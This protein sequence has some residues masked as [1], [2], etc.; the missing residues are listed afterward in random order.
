MIVYAPDEVYLMIFVRAFLINL[1]IFF[2]FKY[3]FEVKYENKIMLIIEFLMYQWIMT[4]MYFK[5]NPILMIITLI[6][7]FQMAGFVHAKGRELNVICH[8]AIFLSVFLLSDYLVFSIWRRWDTLEEQLTKG[9]RDLDDLC[10]IN[11]VFIF[12]I[13][14][15]VIGMVRKY[16]K[17]CK[18][19]MLDKAV[20]IEVAREHK[21]NRKL[22]FII[23][24][25]KILLLGLS[26]PIEAYM[27][28]W[29]NL[30]GNQMMCIITDFVCIGI[31]A[32]IVYSFEKIEKAII[33][34]G[35]L[36]SIKA[37]TKMQLES[38]MRLSERYEG[39][40]KIIHDIRKHLETLDAI[41]Y[42]D[43][44]LKKYADS[45]EKK[46]DILEY[47]FFCT[48]HILQVIMSSKLI[49]CENK[50]ISVNINMI[51]EK[52]DF[53]EDI[54]V[55]AI[56]ANLWDNA[57]EAVENQKYRHRDIKIVI[58]REKGF[59]VLYFEN[60]CGEELLYDNENIVSTKSKDR[61]WG[62]KIIGETIRK[63]GGEFEI[64]TDNG[65]FKAKG[66]IPYDT[67]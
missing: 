49:E 28:S 57:I 61:G 53:M 34:D 63:Y 55:T 35:E 48:N 13:M 65:Y 46:I 4:V 67:I 8:S 30:K 7:C 15:I 58:G 64:V 45:I 22:S 37:K 26:I 33:Y 2:Y 32:V 54:D 9:I 23:E 29:Y 52:F 17:L 10:Y 3:I 60:A 41:L 16:Q 24:I 66:I 47:G 59:I 5:I 21:H 20:G 42:N 38:Y 31:S 51:E 14:V 25:E 18:A 1:L 27:V 62:L 11:I 39:Q 40:R 50:G 43:I 12:N 56:F 6:I 44:M 36:K 19:K